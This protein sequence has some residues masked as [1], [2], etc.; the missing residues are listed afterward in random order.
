MTQYSI[1]GFEVTN[2]CECADLRIIHSDDFKNKAH[3]ISMCLK[4]NRMAAII[5]RLFK[6]RYHIIMKLTQLKHD[7]RTNKFE[8]LWDSSRQLQLSYFPA[9]QKIRQLQNFWRTTAI[10]QFILLSHCTFSC[11]MKHDA[12]KWDTSVNWLLH[13]LLVLKENAYLPRS[14]GGVTGGLAGHWPTQLYAWPTLLK[15][16]A[17]FLAYPVLYLAH[18]VFCALPTHF[19]GPTNLIF[20]WSPF[21]SV[22]SFLSVAGWP[23]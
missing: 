4:A 5:R 22:L 1:N 11:H 14:S 23:H 9:F 13:D 6:E 17:N 20:V 10:F 19:C 3:I 16:P 8:A 7:S 15:G 21:C 18:Q 12:R 2:S